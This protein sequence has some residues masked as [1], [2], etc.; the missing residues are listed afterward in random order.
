MEQRVCVIGGSTWDVLFTTSQADLVNVG[1]R[2]TEPLLAFPYGGKVDAT[3]VIYGY[4]GGAANVAVGL[5]HLGVRVDVVTRIGKEWR[6]QEVIKN[7]HGFGVGTKQIQKDRQLK[8]ALAFIVTAGQGHDHVA[9]V[10]RGATINLSVPSTL[11]QKYQWCY[12]S[13]LVGKDWSAKL[14]RLF[15]SFSNQGGKIFWN[16]GAAQLAEPQKMLSLLKYVTVLDLNN[17]EASLLLRKLKRSPSTS[18]N[19]L[20][21][22]LR[23]LGPELVLITA[24][25]NGAYL[26][27]GN[28]VLHHPIYNVTPINT[29]GAGDAFGSGWLAG[30]LASGWNLNVA[31]QWGMLNSNSVIMHPGAQKGL[32][33]LSTLPKFR[34]MYDE[35]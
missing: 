33:S 21:K 18:I 11:P 5:A 14:G 28:K 3:E 30:Y 17:D 7:F 31:M 32:L 10:S 6:G 22:N 1:G 19:T 26:D 12:V 29:T 15:K 13:A 34:A 27:D 23:L 9:F 2:R 24:G 35:S 8:T 16:P 4:G 20:V 25:K